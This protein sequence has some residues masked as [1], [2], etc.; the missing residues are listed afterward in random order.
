MFLLSEEDISKICSF[1]TILDLQ[2]LIMKFAQKLDSLENTFYL[3]KCSKAQKKKRRKID[4]LENLNTEYKKELKQL[5]PTENDLK[6]Q[7][8]PINY[9]FLDEID[10]LYQTRYQKLK[11]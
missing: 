9:D 10:S 11:W 1:Q 8:L 3:L 6:E 4:N 7:R 5:L 2:S